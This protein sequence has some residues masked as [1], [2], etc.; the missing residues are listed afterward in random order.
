MGLALVHFQKYWLLRHGIK[1]NVSSDTPSLSVF[2]KYVN[3]RGISTVQ[4]DFVYI[5]SD[6]ANSDTSKNLIWTE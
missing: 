6:C 5:A 2:P 4:T 1:L 3:G